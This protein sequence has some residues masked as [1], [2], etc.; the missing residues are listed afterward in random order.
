[1]RNWKLG[2]KSDKFIYFGIAILVGVLVWTSFSLGL[3]AGLENFFEDIL[4]FSKA[5]DPE[6]VIIAVDNDSINRIGQ[7]PWPREIFSQAFLRLNEAQPKVV[8]FDVMLS[9]PSRLGNKDDLS[10]A[11]ALNKISY[12]V[13]LPVEIFGEDTLEPLDVF[14]AQKG[15]NLGHVNLIIDKDGIVRKFPFKINDFRAF[16]YEVIRKAGVEVSKE[17]LGGADG[18]RIAYAG[19]AGS[20]RRVPFW[21]LLEGDL[22]GQ[23]KDKIVLIGATAPDLH[24]EQLTPLGRGAAMP[25]VE[26]Q[27]NIANMLIMGYRLIPLS[28]GW[29]FF[30]IFLAA[31][32]P[33]LAFLLFSRSL[34]PLFINIFLGVVYLILII[35]LFEKG[36]AA[37]IIHIN[38]AWILSTSSLFGY[39]YFVGEK[40]RREMRNLFSKYVSKDVLE[41][42]LADPTKVSLGGEEKEITVFFSD[43]RGFT[44]LSEKTTPKELVRILNRYFTAMSEEIL[45]NA[46]VLDKYIGDAIMAFWGAPVDDPGQA[47]NALKAALGMLAKLKELNE[48][49]RASGDPEINIGI[50]IYTGPAVVGNMGSEQRFDYTVMGDTVNV[51]SRLEGLNK[52][53]QTRLIIGESTKNKITLRLAQGE[54]DYKFRFLGSVAVKGRKEPLNIYTLEDIIKD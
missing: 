42:I 16:S 32:L 52:E 36:V 48:E 29:S 23:L 25:G 45:K 10:L 22:S 46:G 24:D 34:K 13:V 21:R 51:A 14:T 8:G 17:S 19:P 12:S 27:A 53:Y 41:E 3:F 11:A 2:L 1:M 4:F 20:I 47:D 31:V 39:R 40:E 38:L 6:I 26:I 54:K 30:W 18:L 43:I 33:A 28:K 9:E 35:I 49:L 15:V 5:I 37:N 7:W 50:G 44:T